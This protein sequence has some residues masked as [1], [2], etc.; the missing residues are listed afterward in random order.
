MS[1]LEAQK[2]PAQ[3]LN[4]KDT[5]EPKRPKIPIQNSWNT[6][7]P[8]DEAPRKLSGRIAVT[9]KKLPKRNR[10]IDEGPQKNLPYQAR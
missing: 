10:D 9:R 3:T 1:P 6:V 2:K 8:Q 4:Y 7:A 5:I